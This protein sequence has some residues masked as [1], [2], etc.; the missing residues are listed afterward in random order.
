MTAAYN[1]VELTKT[2][3]I[4]TAFAMQFGRIGSVFIAISIMLFAFSTVLGWSHY[5]TKAAEYL[6]DPVRPAGVRRRCHGG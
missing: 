2:N 4:S 3:L 1:G 5:G 6:P